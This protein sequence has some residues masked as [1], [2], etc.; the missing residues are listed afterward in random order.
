MT[1][2]CH[3]WQGL[4]QFTIRLQT[5]VVARFNSV[6]RIA[7][8]IRDVPSEPEADSPID[9][10][11]SWPT[12]G[13]IQFDNVT[14]RYRDGLPDVIK[15]LTLSIG[16]GENIG[17]VVRFSNYALLA[18]HPLKSLGSPIDHARRGLN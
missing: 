11:A 8:Y 7:K 14:L 5:E 6:D 10:P 3:R 12:T 4:F 9:P 17:I 13:E 18:K 15:N 1:T 16:A 2:P